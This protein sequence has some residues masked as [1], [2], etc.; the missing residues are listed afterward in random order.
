[1]NKAW[2]AFKRFWLEEEIPRWI[3]SLLVAAYLCGLGAITYL[4][5]RQTTQLAEQKALSH[6]DHAIFLLA[7]LIERVEAEDVPEQEFL[8]HEFSRRLDCAHLHIVNDK[9]IVIASIDAVG[10]GQPNP[11][12]VVFGTRVESRGQVAPATCS[13]LDLGA[14][15]PG[16]VLRHYRLPIGKGGLGHSRALEAVLRWDT[17]IVL[18]DGK[19][20][21]LVIVL[22]AVGVLG[23][24]YHLM[25]RHFRG[26]SCIADNLLA[27]AG[28]LEEELASLRVADSLGEVACSWNK[29][30]D[31]VEGF[32]TEA[33]RSTAT[34]EL[35]QVLE[36]SSSG[37]LA[38]AIDAVP[39]GIL[40]IADEDLLIHCNAAAARL[41]GW[42]R[43]ERDHTRL[44]ELETSETGRV[45]LE[46][47]EKA[48][49][50]GGTHEGHNEMVECE[51]SSYRVRVVPQRKSRQHD[52]FV[53]VISDVSQQVRA[54]R[55]REEF[56]SQ[57]THELR[58][59]LT[60]IRAYSE[61]LSSG[62]FD[63]PKVVSECYNVI[64]KE[65]RRLSRLVEDILS[66]SQL[67][68]GSIQ[69]LFDEV[70]VRSLI[71][72]AVR[73]VRAVADEKNMD[74][75]AILPAKLEPIRADRDK[76]AVVLNNLLGNALKYTQPGGEIRVGCQ[77]TDGNLLITVKDNGIGIDKAEQEHVFEKFRRSSDP[78]VQD[79]TGTGIGLTTAR[80]IARRHGGDIELMSEKDKGSTFVV[81]LPIKKSAVP[82]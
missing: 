21:L 14:D 32:R 76:L 78:Q 72:E 69:I 55:A 80:E 82:A 56:V 20:W 75:Q 45:V 13:Q 58:T 49:S 31:L 7:E 18:S 3:G 28:H 11:L 26:V 74:L 52:A 36:R 53:V 67:E 8:L 6:G 65:T 40:V 25:R 29:L 27:H 79:E 4:A 60:N 70:D 63:D 16:V 59:P 66:M 44:S 71:Q 51:G 77:I 81:K 61:T 62:M 46:V 5:Y 35:R 39:D 57:V 41:M 23:I 48:R 38:D 19:T 24:V 47:V 17:A 12:T 10:V 54:D 37:E 50:P 73:D 30:I 22:V 9:G 34:S 15:G 68:V 42:K 1:M 64:N 33:G 2:T 43:E